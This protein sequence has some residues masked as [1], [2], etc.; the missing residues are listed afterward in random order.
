MDR[1]SFL[2]RSSLT[3]GAIAV[4]GQGLSLAETPESGPQS[5]NSYPTHKQ[6]TF[7]T[8]KSYTARA[9]TA[10]AA[11]AA[12][13][14]LVEDDAT[15]PPGAGVPTGPE[16]TLPNPRG[17]NPNGP[18]PMPQPYNYILISGVSGGMVT[19]GPTL[20]V[21]YEDGSPKTRYVCTI[22]M[23]ANSSVQWQFQQ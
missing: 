20:E 6:R 9:A 12:A 7:T 16:T 10:A 1:R 14:K 8:S 18:T 5:G 19:S 3:A 23:N 21:Y 13:K 17:S 22:T 15:K 11:L 4:L 2:K